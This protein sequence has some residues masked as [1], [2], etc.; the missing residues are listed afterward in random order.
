MPSNPYDAHLCVQDPDGFA[1]GFDRAASWVQTARPERAALVHHAI[2]TSTGRPW[3]T[4]AALIRFQPD[5]YGEGL[6]LGIYGLVALEA[7]P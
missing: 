4:T 7:L 1:R 2:A 5:A 6:A 3:S